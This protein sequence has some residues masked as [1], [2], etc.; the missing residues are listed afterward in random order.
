M[1]IL[2]DIKYVG[3][4]KIDDSVGFSDLKKADYLRNKIVNDGVFSRTEIEKICN[5]F[6][7]EY[8]YTLYSIYARICYKGKFKMQNGKI[9][10]YDIVKPTDLD[11]KI[12]LVFETESQ[13]LKVVFMLS[14]YQ[15]GD[16]NKA[17]IRKYAIKENENYEK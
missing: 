5:S 13:F 1:K 11:A 15:N 3:Q 7:D 14:D 10:N 12:N 4:I 2:K 17:K 8:V 6:T 16:I 9:L